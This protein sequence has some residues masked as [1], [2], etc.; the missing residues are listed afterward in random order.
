MYASG[1]SYEITGAI[2]QED[3]I[4]NTKDIGT[5]S[6]NQLIYDGVTT[7]TDRY[8]NSTSKNLF[9][10]AGK[11]GKANNNRIYVRD[12]NKDADDSVVTIQTNVVGGGTWRNDSG[13]AEENIAV[14]VGDSKVA[15]VYGG[16]V[17]FDA[18]GNP[19]TGEKTGANKNLVILDLLDNGKVT[20]NVYGGYVSDGTTGGTTTG[21][22]VYALSGTVKGSIVGGNKDNNNTLILG[23]DTSSIGTINAGAI[24]G[25]DSLQFNTLEKNGKAVLNLT[26]NKGSDLNNTEI[27]FLQTTLNTDTVQVRVGGENNDTLGIKYRGDGSGGAKA[28]EA[29][30]KNAV[31][32]NA[33][34]LDKI[35]VVTG[36]ATA[37]NDIDENLTREDGS[38]QANYGIGDTLNYTYDN[39]TV[40]L[41]KPGKYYLIKSNENLEHYDKIKI[42]EPQNEKRKGDK[43]KYENNQ[44]IEL[45][46][47]DA[48]QPD[49][50]YRILDK[51][52]YTRN[53]RGMFVEDNKSLLIT[54]TDSIVE[55]WNSETKFDSNEFTRFNQVDNKGNR[56]YI[57]TNATAN[58]GNLN[59]KTIYGGYSDNNDTSNNN[60]YINQGA[61]LSNATIIGGYSKSGTVSNNTVDLNN[62][63]VIADITLAQTDDGIID[64]A[65]N[66]LVNADNQKITGSLTVAKSDSANLENATY[67]MPKNIEITGDFILANSNSGNTSNN[68]LD[69]TNVKAT[70]I[71]VGKSSSG[72]A[73]NNTINIKG[74]KVEGN[75]YVGYSQSGNTNNNI[76][77]FEKGE[78]TGTIYGGNNGTGNTLNVKDTKLKAGNVAN[79]QV[80][81]FDNSK[82]AST[83]DNNANAALIITK[84]EAT[85]L[86]G[87]R[88]D[89]SNNPYNI[90]NN[91]GYATL[92][93]NSKYYLI[94]NENSTLTNYDQITNTPM[95]N[96][97]STVGNGDIAV[98]AL[99]TD[100]IYK[101]KSSALYTR[102]LAGMFV[103]SDKKDLYI[104]GANEVEE[105]WS[106]SDNEFN[107][108]EFIKFGKPDNK[109]NHIYI[110]ANAGNLGGK[111]IYGGYSDNND[112]SNNNIYINQG[113]NLSNATII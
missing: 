51:D 81:N 71:Y 38:S 31:S 13:G 100:Q 93:K 92:D 14:V 59:G 58:A 25:F 99:Q 103:S 57:E 12:L 80:I 41:T 110:E 68:T 112:T 40:D 45:E 78:V 2:V 15:N 62:T 91:P 48:Y 8:K 52:T 96:P 23:K 5:A 60:I 97:S 95:P 111:T 109:D 104:T 11:L 54:G 1:N 30:T 113:A 35:S 4:G 32:Y 63:S 49:Q 18:N 61:N 3:N 73:S 6:Y 43:I 90:E 66:K 56:I 33:K 101:I 84:N 22:A 20:E 70:N 37:N 83:K 24:T 16:A 76:A 26:G 28:I 87:V 85:D 108:N 50:V 94:R 47:V 88:I 44:T 21:N 74:D 65:T 55:D 98:G 64:I 29:L 39:T 27:K 105:N 77:N 53:L 102:N 19:G 106:N 75:I 69:V 72:E 42:A 10:G 9:G 34:T 17:G 67:T 82:L 86:S 107:S 89:I 46:I 7:Y 79:F 36:G